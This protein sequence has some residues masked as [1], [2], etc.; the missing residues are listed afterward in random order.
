MSPEERI[1]FMEN[2]ESVL[3]LVAHPNEE[4]IGFSS[5]CIGA[6]VVSVTDGSWGGRAAARR[7]GFK[8]ACEILGARRAA[9]LDLPDISP[10]RLPVDVLIDRLR[11]LG[12]YG[13]VYTHSPFE[14]HLHQ[15]DVVLAASQCFEEVWVRSLGGY[16]AEAHVLDRPAYQRK[17]EIMNTIYP[18]DLPPLGEDTH[19]TA[20]AMLA[21]VA[22]IESFVPARW[23]EVHQALALTSPEIR[24]DLPN[25]W[26]FEV[27]TYEIERYQR[28]CEV[29]AQACQEEPPESILDLGAC[30]GLMTL[31]LRQ[32][33]PAAKIWAV[34]SHPIFASRIWERLGQEHNIDVLE[35]SILDIPLSADLIVMAEMLCY[36]PEPIM[37]VLKRLRA[38]YLLTSYHGLFDACVRRSLQAFGWRETI[39]AEILPRF[40]P[41]D[42]RDS[43]LIAQRPGSHIRLWRPARRS[44]SPAHGC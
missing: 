43:L 13:R 28:T 39:G 29:L 18:R 34:E 33:F 26:A 15:R 1:V 5:V 41:V 40:E 20:E 3:V 44:L 9:L 23:S 31:R 4:T 21:D 27:S 7:H 6:D 37:S 30:E 17:L 16:A 36:V 14:A 10:W 12:S 11:E 24:A 8:S 32:L 42:G 38:N 22:G 2:S 19:R 25:T 35:A